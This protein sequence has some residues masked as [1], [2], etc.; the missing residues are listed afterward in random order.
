MII[1]KIFEVKN[2]WGGILQNLFSLLDLGDYTIA[3]LYDEIIPSCEREDNGD[4]TNE[5]VKD[6]TLVGVYKNS[7]EFLRALPK[8]DYYLLFATI[9]VCDGEPSRMS[10]W[11]DYFESNC[12]MILRIDDVVYVETYSKEKSLLDKFT[13]ENLEF[14]SDYKEIDDAD[15]SVIHFPIA[16]FENSFFDE[17]DR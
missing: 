14:I 7:N 1:G 10:A 17:G 9:I 4:C 12:I 2:K 13:A 16:E 3:V 5:Y 11:G 8:E 6:F 15:V